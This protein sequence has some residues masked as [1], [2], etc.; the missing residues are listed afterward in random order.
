MVRW[1]W[2]RAGPCCRD[3][4]SSRQYRVE[5]SGFKYRDRP[6]ASCILACGHGDHRITTAA[7]MSWWQFVVIAG[8]LGAA[9]HV[10]STLLSPRYLSNINDVIEGRGCLVALWRWLTAL[11]FLFALVGVP[12]GTVLWLIYVSV[13]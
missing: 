3:E 8:C 12:L 1:D 4:R 5:L 11:V 9:V 10:L 6:I 7:S 2:Q 13:F